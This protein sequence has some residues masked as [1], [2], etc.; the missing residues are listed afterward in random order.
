MPS[1]HL[2]LCP[3]KEKQLKD[4]FVFN[5][6]ELRKSELYWKDERRDIK[7]SHFISWTT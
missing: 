2:I 4:V 7:L 1:N 6:S 3:D 5:Y